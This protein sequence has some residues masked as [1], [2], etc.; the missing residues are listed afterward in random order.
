MSTLNIGFYEDMTKKIFQL[1]SNMHL[2][3]SFVHVLYLVKLKYKCELL[4][5]CVCV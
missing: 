4:S 2:I 5:V 1:S 3:A